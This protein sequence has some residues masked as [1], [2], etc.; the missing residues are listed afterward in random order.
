MSE[1]YRPPLGLRNPHL[2]TV[3]SSTV[4]KQRLARQ[5]RDFSNASE[6]RILAVAGVRLKVLTNRRNAAPQVILIPGWLGSAT[7]SYM[8]SA[9]ARL[10]SEGFTVTRINLRDHGDTA[11]LNSGL[12]HSALINEVI[13]LVDRLVRESSAP[14]GLLGFSLGGNFALRVTRALPEL[15]TLA[16]APAIRPRV[17]MSRIDN[18]LIYQRY[19]VHKWRKVWSQKQAAYPDLYNFTPAMKISTVSALT[20]YF[21]RYHVTEFPTTQDYFTAYDLSGDALSGVVAR[22]LVADDDPIIPVSHF[23]NLPPSL[24]IENTPQGGHTAYLKNW[25]LE[26]WVDDYAHHYFAPLLTP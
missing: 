11:A 4:R 7:S 8:Q 9:A 19:F 1:V 24:V 26:S 2:Q 5:L 6:T 18:N 12:F 13:A 23:S 17:T 3:L 25:R 21:I 22:L 10:H 15:R 16:V 20:D 14:A